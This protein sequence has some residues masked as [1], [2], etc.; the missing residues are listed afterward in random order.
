VRPPASP[1]EIDY[2]GRR[3]RGSGSRKFVLLAGAAAAGAVLLYGL[4]R[5]ADTRPAAST[6][7][8]MPLPSDT[9][10]PAA[11][12]GNV[13]DVT[14]P[15]LAASMGFDS[16]DIVIKRNDTLDR[17]FRH[18]NLSV[19]DLATLR[20]LPDVRQ[21]LDFLRPGDA[22]TVTHQEGA[23]KGLVR[24][25]NDTQTLT[26]TRDADNSFAA[27]IVENPLEVAVERKQGQITSSLFLSANEAGISDQTTLT[28]AHIFAWDIDFVLDIR[29]GDRFTVVYEKLWQDGQFV[30]D[31]NILAAEFVNNG[32]TFRAVRYERANGEG[33]YFTPEGRSMRK[34]FLRAPLEFTRI[35]SNFNPRR[36]HPV[37][38][39]I[40]AHKGVDY[41]A[42]Q[43]TPVR[44]SGDAKVISRGWNG[45]YG[46]AVVL[47]HGGGITTLYG[48]LSRFASNLKQGQRVKQGAVIGYVGKTGL[49]SGPHLHY[50]YRLNGVHRNP[51][52][53]KLPDAQP[54]APE[55][56]ADFTQRSLPLLAHL[57]GILPE[58]RLAQR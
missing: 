52:T 29:V 55:L 37:L 24:R 2:S 34:A 20:N 9:A 41:A 35:S 27:A 30:R 1:L 15:P 38:N 45:G 25:L 53:V 47:E 11:T 16:I 28:L 14:Q 18:R 10:S 51:R 54:I 40:R 48:H 12:S 6:A 36:R 44:A 19:A 39:T 4:T 23:L 50:E 43:G 13:V 32:R 21:A 17:I 22:L 56:L 8:L 31:G 33:E 7:S 42:P 57:D 58:R 46:N 26:V 5:T 49:A 3:K